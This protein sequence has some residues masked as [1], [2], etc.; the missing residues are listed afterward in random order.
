MLIT[1]YEYSE[2]AGG[3][4]VFSENL[5][6]IFPDLITITNSKVYLSNTDLYLKFFRNNDVV[7]SLISNRMAIKTMKRVHVDVLFVN[8][9]YGWYLTLKKPEV[10]LI[11]IFHGCYGGVANYILKQGRK[12]LFHYYKDY[13]G[14]I[15]HLSASGKV[16]V[17]VSEFVRDLLKQYYD[18]DS[19]VIP[20]GVDLE[21]FESIGKL[22]ARKMLFLPADRRI[23]IFVGPLSYSKGFDII[24][25]LAKE[26]PTTLFI[27]VSREVR[28][29]WIFPNILLFS[30]VSHLDMP[31]FYS[32]ADFFIFPSRFEGC[33]LS[34][35]EAMA[36]NVPV[37]T[38]A[39]GS[40][41]ALN[42][43]QTFGYVMPLTGNI[44]D[45]NM[46]ISHVLERTTDFFPREHIHKNY[47]LD[48]F[49]D[50]YQNLIKKTI[51]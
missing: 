3:V 25:K 23:G 19:I 26:N 30:N 38:S 15:E 11:N 1:P 27:V 48:L 22:K 17:S 20:N 40:F 31:K 37:I 5:K 35:L 43:L 42:G 33:S 47:S 36:C 6:K 44:D 51:A 12:L 8:G 2:F 9:L 49:R 45:Y 4:E 24:V 7:S 39:T 14:F 18:I 13:L 21:V 32:A 10:P 28:S 41:Y 46:A 29:S 34:I 16:V 50:R